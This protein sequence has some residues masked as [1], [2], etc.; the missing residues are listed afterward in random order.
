MDT[1]ICNKC[2]IPLSVFRSKHNPECCVS[3]YLVNDI[4]DIFYITPCKTKAALYREQRSDICDTIE[5]RGMKVMSKCK[6]FTPPG[7]TSV[8][9]MFSNYHVHDLKDKCI[10]KAKSLSILYSQ[11]RDRKLI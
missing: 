4:T 5:R 11:L 3:N 1:S 8:M 9:F 6:C 10:L 2:K 7:S